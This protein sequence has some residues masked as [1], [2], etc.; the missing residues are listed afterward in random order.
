MNSQDKDVCATC[1]GP[2]HSI[3]I[4]FQFMQS[5]EAREYI[6]TV[7]LT[8]KKAEY[9]MSSYEVPPRL[10]LHSFVEQLCLLALKEATYQIFKQFKHPN[11]SHLL[12]LTKVSSCQKQG[13]RIMQE[14][15]QT[16]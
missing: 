4:C 2:A 16:V 10:N 1:K 3:P 7:I 14:K 6:Y 15:K 11:W 8:Q 5:N 12:K 9:Q 13:R